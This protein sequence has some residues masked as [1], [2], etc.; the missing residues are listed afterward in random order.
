MANMAGQPV[1]V[2]RE[3]TSRN[4]G[5]TAQKNNIAAAKIIGEVIKSTLGPRGM[6]KMLVDSLGDI[7]ITN[8]G[9]TILEKIDVEHPA[10]KMVIEVAKTQDDEVGDGTTT[11]VVLT[12]ELLSKA[13]ELVEQKIHPTTI[14]SGY[15]RAYALSHELLRKNSMPV[16]L[17]DR[18]LLRKVVKTAIGSKSLGL[19]QDR[20]AEMAIDAVLAVTAEKG[21]KL[22]ADKDDIQINKKEGKSLGDSELVKGVIVDKE[23]VH[24]GMPKVLQKAKIA[25]L[26]APFEIEKTEIS[27]EIRIRDPNKIQAFLDEETSILREMVDKVAATGANVV[28]C[29]KGIDD[30]AQFFLAKK[31]IMAVRRVKKSDMEKLSKATGGR[32]IT[33]FEDL[34]AKDLGFAGLVQEKKIGEDKMV[35]VEQCKN[36]KSVAVLIRAGLERQLDEAERAFNDAISNVINVVKDNR[37]VAGGGAIEETMA[38]GV[39][40]ASGELPGR[41]QLAFKAFSETLESIPRTLAE[42]AGLDPVDIMTNLRSMHEKTTK[43]AANH[44]V[45]VF[46]G[47]VADMVKLGV[48]EPLVVKE[49]ALKSSFEAAS[50]ILRIDDVVAASKKKFEKPGRGGE[51]E[52]MPGGMPGGMPPY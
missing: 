52:G 15:R 21:G 16:D 11:A 13:E 10:A 34:S 29:Q 33:N 32:V 30:T 42:N 6:D 43:S 14:I 35:F 8:D 17:K 1:I 2:L 47:K 41:E 31:G 19:A 44:G 50:M 45:N 49:Q 18:D 25:L 3:G 48:I 51:G 20:I 12:G 38:T 37:V 40:K 23:V 4:R 27:A 36:P 22:T 26:D 5:R 28:F 9:A 46:S 39:R 24:S 7:V